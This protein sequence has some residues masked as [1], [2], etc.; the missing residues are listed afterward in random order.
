[1][2]EA[3]RR[4][5]GLAAVVPGSKAPGTTERESKGAGLGYLGVRH[6]REVSEG[7]DLALVGG[8]LGLAQQ[9][10]QTVLAEQVLVLVNEPC[11]VNPR[12]ERL[13]TFFF[14]RVPLVEYLFV[15]VRIVLRELTDDLPS[16]NDDQFPARDCVVVSS[17]NEIVGA[18]E[19]QPLG[20]RN[21]GKAATEVFKHGPGIMLVDEQRAPAP[22]TK[23]VHGS[24][25]GFAR[26]FHGSGRLKNLL[27]SPIL[28]SGDRFGEGDLQPEVTGIHTSLLGIVFDLT[29][30]V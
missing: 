28:N 22:V 17:H 13:W 30:F 14:G 2:N 23:L 9:P 18:R 19:S 29:T 12:G 27:T 6:L 21:P 1:M 25:E 26:R 16:A 7:F 11:Y 10:K 5:A 20:R 15:G 24:V 8:L 3:F 4:S